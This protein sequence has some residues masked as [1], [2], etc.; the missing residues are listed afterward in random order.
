MTNLT[1]QRNKAIKA[2]LKKDL[3][4]DGVRVTGGRGTAYGW[5]EVT[6]PVDS[7][8]TSQEVEKKIEE[9]FKSQ[10]DYYYADD[11]YNTQTSCVIVQ[12]AWA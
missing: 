3:Q 12:R 2:F 8:L 1:F 10:L 6:L 11:G 7:V 4:L 5:V 9:K